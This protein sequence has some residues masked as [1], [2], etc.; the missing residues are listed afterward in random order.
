MK[1]FDYKDFKKGTKLKWI[2]VS[3]TNIKN[4]SIPI[5]YSW[6]AKV[7]RGW[8]LKEQ[9]V[10]NDK[11]SSSMQFI[12]DPDHYLEFEEVKLEKNRITKTSA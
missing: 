10:I 9:T 3:Y 2:L 8:L 4:Y 11:S 6:V 7:P 12:E 5:S 1:I